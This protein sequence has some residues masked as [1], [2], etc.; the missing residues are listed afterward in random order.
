MKNKLK[1][2]NKKINS[3]FKN[4]FEIFKIT[5]KSQPLGLIIRIFL[6]IIDIII[7]FLIITFN[8]QI[9]NSIRYGN[10]DNDFKILLIPLISLI[11]ITFFDKIIKIISVNILTVLNL[12]FKKHMT[13]NLLEKCGEVQLKAFDTPEIFDEIKKAERLS[14]EDA[15]SF[16]LSF[17]NS[18]SS[19][20]KIITAFLILIK[21]FPL[22]II[23]GIFGTLQ[24][25]IFKFDSSKKYE[26]M[27]KKRTKILRRQ[28]YYHQLAIKPE[29][30]KEVRLF[31]MSK[32]LVNNRNKCSNEW[33]S[34]EKKYM[35]YTIKNSLK[36]F[37][38]P[39]LFHTAI[40]SYIL[41]NS[42]LANDI[43]IGDF[44]FYLSTVNILGTSF[45]NITH[46]ASWAW[47]SKGKIQDYQNFLNKKIDLRY[48]KQVPSSWYCHQPIIEFDNV[49]YSYLNS[50]SFV[51]KDIS[52]KI[53]PG[54]KIAIIGLNG[55]GKTTIIKL[56]C[57]LYEPTN[58][59]IYL[60]NHNILEYNQK[61]IFKLFSVVFQDYFDY[62]IK[63]RDSLKMGNPLESISDE[64]IIQTLDKIGAK[65]L[66]LEK[67]PHGLDTYYGHNL[68]DN[69]VVFS[70]GEKQKIV[71]ARSLIQDRPFIILDEPTSSL[72]P[73]SESQVLEEFLSNNNNKTS[74]IVSHRLSCGIL[75]NKIIVIENGS[76][77]EQGS[78]SDLLYKKGAYYNLYKIQSKKYILKV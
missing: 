34:L 55:A 28:S 50:D 73:I 63:I 61:E 17:F 9:I 68:E 52:F 51:L 64:D 40:P 29:F 7:P 60:D 76:L 2:E 11:V 33:I 58:G 41:I 42:I 31:Y 43:N 25:S 45:S 37:F 21:S 3:F 8:R 78:H 30:S 35:L 16:I 75:V 27:D 54:E 22:L 72:D 67:M 74:I 36:W 18:I 56:L 15:Q 62:S 46:N 13:E 23:C 1:S 5:Y 39:L 38:L 10:K 14:V 26:E 32:Y 70:G 48:G 71:L 20:F 6:L 44:T 53:M 59:N 66:Y 4:L 77:I 65:K 49:S 47:I 57:G 19:I 12:K 69:G 24:V